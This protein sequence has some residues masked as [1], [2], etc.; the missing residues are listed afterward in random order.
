MGRIPEAV[1]KGE[2]DAVVSPGGLGKEHECPE[3]CVWLCWDMWVYLLS[4][5]DCTASLS[6]LSNILIV[7]NAITWHI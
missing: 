3:D 4:A 6:S 2:L 1:A 5:R 7:I